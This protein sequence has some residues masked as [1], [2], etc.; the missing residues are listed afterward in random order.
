MTVNVVTVL[1]TRPRHSQTREWINT[2]R[3][4][5]ESFT[6]VSQQFP[7][8]FIKNKTHRRTLLRVRW[9]TSCRT[10]WSTAS[11]PSNTVSALRPRRT[12]PSWRRQWR[13]PPHRLSC[14][15]G[16]RQWRR[17]QR[18]LPSPASAASRGKLGSWEA[19]KLGSWEAGKLGSWEAE[20]RAGGGGGG[21]VRI[22][23]HHDVISASMPLDITFDSQTAVQ[24]QSKKRHTSHS[25]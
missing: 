5:T 25:S 1:W 23:G 17:R 18:P 16:R 9:R 14:P 2:L 10:S 8:R 7:T 11:L 22:N 20:K 19:G 6:S 15:T 24:T 21:G 12:R 4:L 3:N 13:H